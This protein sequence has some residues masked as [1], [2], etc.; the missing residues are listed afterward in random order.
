MTFGKGYQ[1]PFQLEGFPFQNTADDL[2]SLDFCRIWSKSRC[3]FDG[4]LWEGMGV[5]KGRRT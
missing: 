1:T 4:P 3:L 5:F 2:F